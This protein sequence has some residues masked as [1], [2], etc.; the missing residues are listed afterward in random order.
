MMKPRSMAILRAH[1]PMAATTTYRQKLRT[2]RNPATGLRPLVFPA[3]EI[4]VPWKWL[5]LC[6][7]PPRRRLFMERC[8]LEEEESCTFLWRKMVAILMRG[9]SLV[10]W[11]VKREW[12]TLGSRKGAMRGIIVFLNAGIAV[13]T[14]F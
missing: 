5:L 1:P 2:S 6:L 14:G 10:C 4:R 7:P 9:G 8:R 11:A 13:I 12:E 3:I